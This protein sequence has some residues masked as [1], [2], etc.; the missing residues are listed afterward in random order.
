M[1]LL[2][3]NKLKQKKK[4]YLRPGTNGCQLAIDL[5]VATPPPPLSPPFV[6]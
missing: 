6:F 1:G 5:G 2:K 3:H 4:I